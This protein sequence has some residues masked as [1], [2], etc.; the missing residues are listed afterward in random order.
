MD[1]FLKFVEVYLILADAT[2]NLIQ[3]TFLV[4]DLKNLQQLFLTNIKI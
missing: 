4:L 2:A 3:G 1:F